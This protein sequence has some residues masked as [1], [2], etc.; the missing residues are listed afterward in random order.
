MASQDNY[1]VVRKGIGVGTQALYAD[2]NT[3][4]V[5]IGKTVGN[6]PLDVVGKVYSS[7]AIY[8]QN[9]IGVGTT[10]NYQQ[11]DVIGSAYVSN[12][13]FQLRHCKLEHLLL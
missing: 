1:F 12:K 6:Y 9:N 10:S 5:A 13:V 4:T 7:D 3:K 2:G 11:F 8:A